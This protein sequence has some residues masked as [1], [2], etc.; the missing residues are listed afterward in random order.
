M[1]TESKKAKMGTPTKYKPEYVSKVDD[2]LNDPKWVG[3]YW[4][5]FHKTRGDKTNSFE[6]VLKLKLAKIEGFAEYIDTPLR[7]IYEWEAKYDDFSHAL[8]KIRKKQH[9]MLIDGALSGAYASGT[10]NLILSTNHGYRQ[11]SDVTTDGQSIT[12]I[13][14]TYLDK[15]GTEHNSDS[16]TKTN[17]KS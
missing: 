16:D 8:D 3:E 17:R 4:E 1:A 9:N 6:R 7:N 12:E 11:K 5:E 13:K 2:Y 15:N 10:A 14:V